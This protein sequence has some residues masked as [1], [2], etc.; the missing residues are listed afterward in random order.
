MSIDSKIITSLY[1]VIDENIENAEPLF[2]DICKKKKPC[3]D[4]SKRNAK[5]LVI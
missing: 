4:T 5:Y 1:H 3:V 2:S